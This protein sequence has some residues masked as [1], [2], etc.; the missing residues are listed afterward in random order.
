MSN[1]LRVQATVT[2]R[3]D[4]G[5]GVVS[6]ALAVGR[7]YTR[8]R[9]G[10]FLHLALDDFDPMGGHWPE[11][12]VFSIA[13]RPNQESLTVVF[14]VKGR[15][16]RRM[17]EE[18]KVGRQVW[19]RLPYGDFVVDGSIT[20]AHLVLVAGGTGITP[21]VPLLETLACGES[22]LSSRVSLIYGVR[23]APLLLFLETIR[24]C[25]AN[26]TGFR[27]R[28]F[29]EDPAGAPAD[30]PVTAG[31]LSAE[32][33]LELAPNDA[34]SRFHLSGPPAMIADLTAALG[35][36]GVRPGAIVVDAWE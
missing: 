24:A 2:S 28:L 13:S 21:Y 9:P 11:S 12:R 17:A 31:R 23:C 36:S 4:H 5:F 18:L 3:T 15:F 22:R 25:E 6:V 8:F 1:P 7:R 14:S 30:L 33:I 19:L 16:T 32:R 20:G 34:D 29:V 10:Q 35:G 27:A 26:Q